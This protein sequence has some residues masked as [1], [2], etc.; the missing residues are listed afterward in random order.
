MQQNAEFI[1]VRIF[2]TIYI[3][4][5]LYLNDWTRDNAIYNL[6][7]VYSMCNPTIY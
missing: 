5:I 6:T 1:V 3:F 4:L 2:N 7:Y